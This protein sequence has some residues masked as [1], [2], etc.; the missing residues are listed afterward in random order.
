MSKE[1]LAMVDSISHERGLSKDSIFKAIESALALVAAKKYLEEDVSL[2]VVIDRKTGDYETFRC[3]T[4][5]ANDDDI[6]FPGREISLSKAREL[7]QE[8]IEELSVGD[9]IEEPVPSLPFGRIGIQ[10]AKQAILQKVKEAGRQKV[11]ER[12]RDLIGEIILGRVSKVTRKDIFVDVSDNIEAV[13]SRNHLLARENYRVNDR[14]RAYL[15]DVPED[16]RRGPQLLLSR[17]MP[18]F[19]ITL[20]KMEVPEIA[21]EVIQ[22]KG[23]AR[24]PGVRAKIAVKTNDGRIDPI[25]ACV[26]M[27]GARVQAVSNELHGE[28]I[29]IV[30][31]SDNP[32]QLVI[33]AMAPAEI[34]SIIV[35]EENKSMD[36]IVEKEHLSQAIGRNGQNI[37]LASDLTGWT[38]NVMT[39]EQATSKNNNDSQQLSECFMQTLDIDES[40]S[41]VLIEAGFSSLADIAYTEV[42]EIAKIEGLDEQLA[43]ELQDRASDALLAEQISN[44]ENSV[45]LDEDLLQLKGM[46]IELAKILADHGI[47]VREHLAD[48]S[49]DELCELTDIDPD[50]AAK[51]IMEARAPWFE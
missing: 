34:K 38:L 18:E 12:Y 13:L 2:R 40:V 39:Q 44:Q 21:E 15:Y 37:R 29:D 47:K 1:I 16:T 33:N 26:G 7:Y 36:L 41:S 28:R 17:T 45:E 8:D 19:L 10:Q 4:V 48:Q 31:W 22:V 5:V 42:S 3:W 46:T 6:T 14:V 9:I 25:G 11:F 24:D 27:G 20:F 35:D 50:T 32:A 49:V 51:L 30:L 43:K 23:A